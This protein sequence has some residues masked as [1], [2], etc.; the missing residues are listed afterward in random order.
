MGLPGY[1]GCLE[2]WEREAFPEIEAL[3]VIFHLFNFRYFFSLNFNF[4]LSNS[5]TLQVNQD[6]LKF[7]Y[8]FI[9]SCKQCTG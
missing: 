7:G 8:F 3:Q 6:L 1:L 2:K 4:L 9:Q 5:F